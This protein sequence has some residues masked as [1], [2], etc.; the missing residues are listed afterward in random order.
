MSMRCGTFEK[1]QEN[2]AG[3]TSTVGAYLRA[4]GRSSSSS[5]SSETFNKSCGFERPTWQMHGDQPSVGGA[6]HP[7]ECIP[8]T[9]Y[10]FKRSGCRMGEDCMYCHMSH[11]SKQQ[12][13]RE[14]YK[15]SQR[16]KR[17]VARERAR[18]AQLAES[19]KLTNVANRARINDACFPHGCWSPSALDAEAEGEKLHAS[20]TVPVEHQVCLA[21]TLVGRTVNAAASTEL[22]LTEQI[23]P[24]QTVPR[25]GR[26]PGTKGFAN[27][28][29]LHLEGTASCA[30]MSI[31]PTMLAMMRPF[32]KLNLSFNNMLPSANKVSMDLQLLQPTGSHGTTISK[33]NLELRPDEPCWLAYSGSKMDPSL[34]VCQQRL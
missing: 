31:D 10:C 5:S 12:R 8:C 21:R 23:V 26:T 13:H 27:C 20:A 28:P 14:Q 2:L 25:F 18:V 16:Q 6:S 1:T 32:Q 24:K 22:K 15:K 33:Q 17:F 34:E 3:N 9:F 4:F 30:T 29:A 19:W 11:L 7:N